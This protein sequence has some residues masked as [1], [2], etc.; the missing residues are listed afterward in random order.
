PRSRRRLG[1][2]IVAPMTTLVPTVSEART[3][4]TTRLAA[5][6]LDRDRDPQE[7]AFLTDDTRWQAVLERD[8][9][10]E[11]RFW[12]AVTS[13]GIFCRPTCAARRPRR[14]RARFFESVDAALAA[15]FRACLRCRPTDPGRT[16]LD[17]VAEAC[18][19][20][21]ADELGPS[22]TLA[23]LGER[24]GWSPFHLQRTFRRIVGVSPRQYA[25]SKRVE[26]LRDRLRAA[27]SVT[28]ALYDAGWGSS[29]AFYASAPAHLGMSPSAYRNGGGGDTIRFTI[30]GSPIGRVLIAATERGVCSVRIGDDDGRLAEELHREFPRA[31]RIERNDAVLE[32]WAGAVRRNLEGSEPDLD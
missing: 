18:R 19:L 30:V 31:A 24:V 15:G 3:Q 8:P 5:T 14:D 9:R 2:P 20:I 4:S 11:G 29:A 17:V 10:A 25:E 27:D 6:G 13:T 1:R 21:E 22:L 28:T 23:E 16:Q 12:M 26:R 7:G 32:S